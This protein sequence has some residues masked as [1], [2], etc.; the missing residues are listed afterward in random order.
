MDW[1]NVQLQ[2]PAQI[3]GKDNSLKILQRAAKNGTLHHL[4]SRSCIAAFAQVYQTAYDKLLLVTDDVQGNDSYA[5]VFTNP[6]YQATG[7]NTAEAIDPYCWICPLDDV[8]Q[9]VCKHTGISAVQ[10]WADSKNW[11][12][13]QQPGYFEQSASDT[14]DDNSVDFNIQYCLAKP[15]KQQCSLQYSPPSMIAVIVSNIV[16]TAILLYIWLGVTK[17]P[18]LTIGDGIASFLRRNDIY[19]QGMC[20][21]CDGSATYI[22]PIRA[23]SPSLYNRAFRH[24]AVY[25]DKQRR[26]GSSISTRWALFIF[27]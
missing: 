13:N 15:A 9:E 20:L 2:N 27:W 4:D 11:T 8:S 3:P 21:P 14:I 1:S 10:K 5:L 12:V 23:I 16:K 19:S 17:A 18:I 24:P 6:V 25:R 7:G 22:H 26:W